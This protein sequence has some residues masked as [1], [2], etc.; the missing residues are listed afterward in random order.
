[1][2]P[3][4]AVIVRDFKDLVC[5]RL[6]YALKCEVVDFT[7][8][9]PASRDFKYCDQIRD[10]S[11][12]APANIAEAFGRYRSRDAARFCEFAIASLEETRNHLIDGRDR[13]YL[14]PVLCSRLSNLARSAVKTTKNWMIYLKD[15]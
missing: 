6:A 3:R 12:S 9:G 8:T 13:A 10:A 5:W 11:A 14:T 4:G 15:C 7:A 2:P 1:M